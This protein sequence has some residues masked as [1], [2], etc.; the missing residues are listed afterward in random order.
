MGVSLEIDL[1]RAAHSRASAIGANQIGFGEPARSLGRLDLH[2]HV[3][4]ALLNGADPRRGRDGDV[5][6]SSQ[7][8]KHDVGE[9][10]LLALHNVGRACVVP[11][12]AEIERGDNFRPPDLP[13]LCTEFEARSVRR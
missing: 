8:R 4:V 13:P 1:K 9:L 11:Q 7:A 2:V 3:A 12:Q 6:Q 5:G 10:M